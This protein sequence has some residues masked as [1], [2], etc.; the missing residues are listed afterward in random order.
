MGGFLAFKFPGERVVIRSGEWEKTTLEELPEDR[1]FMTDFEKQV[2]Y[3]F[4][5][6]NESTAQDKLVFPY[7]S[8]ND[9][10]VVNRNAYL[11]GLDVFIHEFEPRGI[12]KA[13][14]SRI[15]IVKKGDDSTPLE[16]FDKL[17]ESYGDEALVYLAS[18]HQ[19]GTWMG[20]T[21]ET[22]LNGGELGIRSMALAGTKASEQDK[23][24]E[25]EY[26]EQQLVAD[27]V[28]EVINTQ[29]PSN[30]EKSELETV[31]KGAVYHLRTNY[32][33]K[34][35]QYKWN[36]LIDALHPT[37]A[38]CGAPR[39]LALDLIRN[40]EPHDRKF[41]AG[42]IG[43]KGLTKLDVFVNL[44][45]MQVLEDHYALYVGGGITQDSDLAAEWRE[46][47]MKSQTLLS[48]LED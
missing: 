4:R 7:N 28:Q 41:Y 46:T 24:T 6:S 23:W 1:F 31:K 44:R 48:V 11:N 22:L 3:A 43:I 40:F 47:E 37:P 2:C 16:L 25:K 34:L 33:F 30:F 8:M 15:N 5:A 27:F 10:F 14:F 35:P 38:V 20:A 45:C 13:V 12:E 32:S 39:E 21:P 17:V 29:A 26:H 42:L 9:V 19:F 18:D 36:A